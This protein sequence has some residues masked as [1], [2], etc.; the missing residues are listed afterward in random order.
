M[1]MIHARVEYYVIYLLK[2][3]SSAYREHGMTVHLIM[4]RI[5]RERKKEGGGGFVA[6]GSYCLGIVFV[7][8]QFCIILVCS[9]IQT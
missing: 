3:E 8:L 5:L 7:Y 9:S 2:G 6:Q 4:L 1:K